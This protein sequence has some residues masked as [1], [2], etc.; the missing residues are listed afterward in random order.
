MKGGENTNIEDLET[1]Q[2]SPL[3]QNG[4][5]IPL[6]TTYIK[7]RIADTCKEACK[8]YLKALALLAKA[9]H[10]VTGRDVLAL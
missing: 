8:V 3:S 6:C 7:Q 1:D 2:R 5:R 10:R 9:L 4:K